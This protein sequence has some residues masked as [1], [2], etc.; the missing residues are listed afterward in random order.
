MC[1]SATVRM[2]D[3]VPGFRLLPFRNLDLRYLDLS[4]LPLSWIPL[5]TFLKA[6]LS[7]V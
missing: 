3:G 6:S 2:H 7:T 5:H 1:V 4:L